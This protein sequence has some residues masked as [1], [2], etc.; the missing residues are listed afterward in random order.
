MATED[1]F[2]TIAE[3]TRRMKLQK[4]RE[5]GDDEDEAACDILGFCACIRDGR[6]LFAVYHEQGPM[7]PR[8]AAAWAASLTSCDMIFVIADAYYKHVEAPELDDTTGLLPKSPEQREEEFYRNHP[9]V[10]PGFLNEAWMRGEREGIS[11]AIMVM[12][13]TMHGPPLRAQYCYTRQGRK[14]TWGKIIS[15]AA[16]EGGG[17]DDY[18]KVGFRRAKEM[19]PQIKEMLIKQHGLMAKEGFSARERSYWTDRGMASFLS[20]KS[21]VKLVHYLGSIPNLGLPDAVFANGQEID[22]MTHEP[23]EYE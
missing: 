20:T 12:R 3:I 6:Q 7:A 9:E 1:S 23:V 16:W 14:L 15:A 18:I 8:E 22:P 21:A 11:E 5:F 2:S 17:I 4:V 13:F 19:Q 10:H